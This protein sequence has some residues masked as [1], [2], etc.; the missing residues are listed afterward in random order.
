MKILNS[1]PKSMR[2]SILLFLVFSF[3]G[4]FNPI[5]NQVVSYTY[6]ETPESGE[7][8]EQV[9]VP[10]ESSEPEEPAQPEEAEP[11]DPEPQ[12]PQETPPVLDVFESFTQPEQRGIFDRKIEICHFPQGEFDEGKILEVAWS[13]VLGHIPRH[14]GDFLIESSRDRDRCLDL[15]EDEPEDEEEECKGL[16][17]DD[18]CR[19]PKC[20]DED[21]IPPATPTGLERH[22]PDEDKIYACGDESFI[23]RMWPDWD[24]NTEEDFDH[25]EYSSFNPDAQG[26]DERIFTE[27]IFEYDGSWIPE[28]GT[29]GF[30]VRA[31]DSTG[32]KSAWALSD[33][34]LEGSCQITYVEEVEEPA[35]NVKIIAQQVICDAE[36]YLPNMSGGADITSSTAQDWVDQSEGHC[37]LQ[38]YRF[39]E[40]ANGG[41]SNPGDETQF[42]GEDWNTTKATGLDGKVKTII[43]F[44]SEDDIPEQLRFRQVFEENDYDYTYRDDVD[45]SSN[46]AELYCHTDVLNYDNFDFIN[47]I[48]AGAKYQCVGFQVGEHPTDI[49]LSREEGNI[50]G[51]GG[52]ETE[53]VPGAWALFQNSELDS[54]KVEWM[55]ESGDGPA[56]LEIQESVSNWLSAQGI[57]HAEL[58]THWLD[59][60]GPSAVKISQ[61]L[62]TIPGAT[63]NILYQASARPNVSA[64]D[65]VL[66]MKIKRP[67]ASNI[68]ETHE[69]GSGNSMNWQVYEYSFIA[70]AP[71]TTLIFKDLGTANTLGPL[72]DDVQVSCEPLEPS[73]PETDDSDEPFVRSA[74]ITA[75]LA[76]EEVSGLVLFDATLYDE[77]GDDSAQWAVREGTCA[78]NTGTVFGN[79]DGFSDSFTWDGM[80][81]SA[82]T[83]VSSWNTGNYCFVFNPTES[84]GDDPIRETQEFTIVVEEE[85]PDPQ[86]PDPEEEEEDDDKKG[87]KKRD[88]SFST[89]NP[90]VLGAETEFGQ[91]PYFTEY[92]K[93]GDSDGDGDTTQVQMLQEF[94]NDHLGTTI[95]EDGNFGKET[96]RVMHM[97]QQKYFSEVIN[98]WGLSGRTTGWFYKTSRVKANAIM[99]CIDKV[100]LED[101]K[102]W[103]SLLEE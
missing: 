86:D 84:V 30:A 97:F 40:W 41:T 82:S 92:M 2:S 77:D 98:P 22:A 54:W 47:G 95:V 35:V 37:W 7:V 5:T 74:E 15:L 25:Y 24:D 81:F 93:R 90:Q 56:V 39:F 53:D 63:Y 58:G 80:N 103:Y 29:Y 61:K 34:T 46:S 70:S 69:L 45:D 57:Q 55:P 9:Q 18:D 68:S 44:D 83:D 48:E 10:E 38:P 28:L 3:V 16:W 8:Q 72:L 27:S 102:I 79:V 20:D 21:D 17:C 87:S 96:E 59:G 67:N 101:P 94:L 13:A 42:G 73:D 71:K 91:C 62:D 66:D 88:V 36:M 31:V 6:A 50:V 49:C 99:G 78:A 75:P 100:F 89:V 60:S 65:N 43:T 1:F 12:E 52:F 33:E 14:N 76:N 19:G 4:F 26:I 32:N 11:K 85:D 23:Q 64:D 51:N